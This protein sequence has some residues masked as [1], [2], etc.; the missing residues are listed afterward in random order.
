MSENKKPVFLLATV[1]AVQPEGLRLILDGEEEAGEKL[2]KCANNVL[3]KAGDRV[4]LTEDSG[5]YMVDYAL[6]VPMERILIPAG[7]ADGQVLAKDGSEDFTLKWVD[8][9]GGAGDRLVYGSSR[10]ILGVYGLIPS[11][12]NIHLG[13]SSNRFGDLYAAGDVLF[14][15][16]YY[17][18]KLGFFGS[19]G[20]TKQTVANSATVATL[21]TALKAY[22]LIG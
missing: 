20:A 13:S 12:T 18:T 3:F 15:R 22:G 7:G 11:G 21:I 9:S 16:A 10:V 4:K 8:V 19:G 1:A 14:G 6:G 17:N 2:Y 5:T